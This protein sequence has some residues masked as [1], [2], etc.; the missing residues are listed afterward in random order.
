MTKILNGR[1]LADFIK[2]RQAR[3]VR[4]LIQHDK[5]QPKLAILTTSRPGCENAPIETYV[6]MKQRYG[7][8]IQVAVEIFRESADAM[9]ATIRELNADKAIH[10]MIIQLPLNFANE[11]LSDEELSRKTDAIVNLVAPEKDVDALGENAILDPATPMAINWLLAGYNVEL[12]GKNIVIVGDGRLVGHPLAKMWRNSG[13]SVEVLDENSANIREKIR[14]ADVIVT[15][16]G[17]PNLITSDDVKLGAVV[18]DAGTASEQGKVVGDVAA[19]VRA[20]D[21]LTIT[22]E[23]GGV[24][25]LTIVALMDNVIRAARNSV[26]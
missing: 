16:T 12:R 1:E 2:A 13:L 18:V 6:R 10:G 24:G 3:Q 9:P 8:D 7:D 19:G 22:P 23:K 11:N 4:G 14:N 5:I 15:A 17:V 21:D 26:A 25:P 20:R